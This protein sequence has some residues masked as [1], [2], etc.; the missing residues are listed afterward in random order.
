MTRP[1]VPVIDFGRWHRDGS[2]D[3]QAV[4]RE[5][6][7]ACE[8]SGFFMLAMHGVDPDLIA[9]MVTLTREFF[10][11]GIEEKMRAYGG[12]NATRGYRPFASSSL[13][14]SRDEGIPPGFER[15]VPRRA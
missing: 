11:A 10:A 7:E 6:G 5:I 2:G 1:V 15:V 12:A 4:A 8:T 3:R 9:R 14:R 13:A